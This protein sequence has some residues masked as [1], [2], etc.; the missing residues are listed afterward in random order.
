MNRL[1]STKRRG[2]RGVAFAAV[3]SLTIFASW[4]PCRGQAPPPDCVARMP[5]RAAAFAFIRGSALGV[6]QG[7]DLAHML[8]TLECIAIWQ[9]FPGAPIAMF[10][11]GAG[12]PT[13]QNRLQRII[14]NP[15]TS[16]DT[17][18]EACRL[19]PL[20]FDLQ[21]RQALIAHA[22]REWGTL[23]RPYQR[24][25][26]MDLGGDEA[27]DL[28]RDAMNASTEHPV[29]LSI[30]QRELRL[31]RAANDED[32]LLKL[33]AAEDLLPDRYWLVQQ[34]ARRGMDRGRVRLAALRYLRLGK[35]RPGEGRSALLKV[36]ARL[37]VFKAQDE[38]EFPSIGDHR[39][40]LRQ[41]PKSRMPWA[42][43]HDRLIKEWRVA[44]PKDAPGK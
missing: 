16:E 13:M 41:E 11:L 30:R 18:I 15:A 8:E 27:V 6:E 31:A 20:K 9:G 21:A 12:D 37:E 17:M 43:E 14:M 5:E 23:D 10:H 34:A 29:M 28:L 4:K 26:L 44:A 24:R 19:L 3:L 40:A 36:C 25:F 39:M 38:I 35:V 33:L 42:T 7:A 2:T 22:R 1:Q 32:M